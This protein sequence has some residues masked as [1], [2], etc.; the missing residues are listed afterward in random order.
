MFFT[1]GQGGDALAISEL[2]ADGQFYMQRIQEKVQEILR[3]FDDRCS[4]C[5]A[6]NPPKACPM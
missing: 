2:V 1:E 5:K 6:E 3:E 4:Y